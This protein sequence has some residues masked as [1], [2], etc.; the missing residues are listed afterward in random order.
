M[1]KQD[2][3][4]KEQKRSLQECHFVKF[5]C[6]IDH[7]FTSLQDRSRFDN[8]GPLTS[9][10]LGSWICR[11]LLGIFTLQTWSSPI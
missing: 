7:T 6:F 1:K 9:P 11:H 8:P 3:W 5:G 10:I 4:M 2:V